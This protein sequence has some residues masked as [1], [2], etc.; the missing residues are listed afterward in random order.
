MGKKVDLNR[1][2]SN[3]N[4]FRKNTRPVT[5]RYEENS[6]MDEDSSLDYSNEDYDESPEINDDGVSANNLGMSSTRELIQNKAS[7]MFDKME[8]KTQNE[9]FKILLKNPATRKIMLVAIGAL[10]VALFIL[11]IIYMVAALLGSS[12]SKGKTA[13]GGYYTN[14]CSEV[15]VIYTDKSDDYAITGSG[16]FAFEDYIAGVVSAE[17]GMF[18]DIEI[19]KSLAITAR[20][21]FLTHD[22]GTCTIESSDRKQVFRDITDRSYIYSDKIY[23]AVEATA[24]QVLLFDGELRSVQYDAFCSIDK[25][26]NYYTIKQKNQK[27]PV[28][29]VDS[30]WGIAES[31]KQGTCA[32]NHGNGISQWGS[33]YLSS[34][35]NYT[36]DELIHYYLGDDVVISA[37]GYLS[38]IAGLEIKDT[39]NATSINKPLGEF[40]A[41][42]GS[43]I[44]NMN[45]FIHDSVV[46]NG[47]GTRAG[48]VTA[49]V[50]FVNYLYDNFNAKIPYYWGGYYQQYGVSPEF[51]GKTRPATSASGSLFYYGGLD[52][53]GFVSW[54][55]KNGGYNISRHT[56][57]G[58]DDMFKDSCKI[59]DKNCIGQP[60]DLINARNYHV[61]MIVAVDEEAGK[62]II[63]EATT[64]NGYNGVVIREVGI[65]TSFPMQDTKI[66]KLDSYYNNSNNADANY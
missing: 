6:Q 49:A 44:D 32:G 8:N 21:Y 59:T 56:T 50:S 48:V 40:L 23:E 16:T 4:S 10:I 55:I 43:S 15:T 41:D 65:H 62:Y 30:Q 54:A 64:T 5:P 33:Y 37:K 57:Q 58:F 51:G 11:F 38:S 42:N 26:E 63:A 36:Y 29:W 28:S 39:T 18:N 1:K 22:G 34:V 31:W 20:T 52:C 53:S 19:Y 24:G 66:L 12:G 9:K 61:Q 47:A 3:T 45:K 60:G 46:S 7:E 27:I 35:H 2:H 25:D 13:I 17:V 14:R